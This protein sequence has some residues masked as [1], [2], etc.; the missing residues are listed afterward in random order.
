MP[1][2]WRTER[3]QIDTIK[4]ERTQ[5]HFFSDVV[6]A[7]VVSSLLKVPILFV[8]QPPYPLPQYVEV[9][10]SEGLN[11]LVALTVNI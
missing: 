2:V 11:G 8:A 3:F 7:V 4:F 6:T 10:L 5:I 1:Y 9:K